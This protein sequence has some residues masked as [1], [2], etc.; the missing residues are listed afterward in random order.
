VSK[1]VLDIA[2]YRVSET[3]FERQHDEDLAARLASL[4]R[5]T[6]GDT[7]PR[8]RG[9]IEERYRQDYGPWQFNQIIAWLRLHVCRFAVQA[10][11]W[12][13][14]AKVYRR[15]VRHKRFYLSGTVPVVVD[16]EPLSSDEILRGISAEFL[17]FDRAWRRKG[18]ALDLGCLTDIGPFL[19]WRALLSSA[20]APRTRV[21]EL[22]EFRGTR[23]A[24]D[25]ERT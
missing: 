2:V 1:G 5:Q 25:D 23:L 4:A 24:L 22:Y 15:R 3:Q 12:L 11:L 10:D 17:R 20:G 6:G 9:L 8:L 7:S 18:L 14:D 19:D 21:L 13:C 16:A